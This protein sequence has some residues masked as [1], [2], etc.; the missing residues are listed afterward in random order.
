LLIPSLLPATLFVQTASMPLVLSCSVVVSFKLIVT[1]ASDV[2]VQVFALDVCSPLILPCR[3]LSDILNIPLR[4]AIPGLHISLWSEGALLLHLALAC[5]VDLTV[6]HHPNDATDQGADRTT[7]PASPT[8]A[9]HGTVPDAITARAS[10]TTT[11]RAAK[12][13]VVPISVS[14]IIAVA[15][16]ITS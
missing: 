8:V 9:T 2:K 5:V 1:L 15:I 10:A 13:I 7:S 4:F 12:S 3:N 6:G 16:V 11:A 14:V